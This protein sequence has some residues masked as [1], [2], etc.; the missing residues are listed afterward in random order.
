MHFD[1]VTWT[2]HLTKTI[3]ITPHRHAQRLV[4]QVILELIRVIN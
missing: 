3:T 1:S 4:S 2:I